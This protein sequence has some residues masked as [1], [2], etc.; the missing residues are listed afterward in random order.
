M[1]SGA[2]GPG[3][4]RGARLSPQTILD[5]AP[6]LLYSLGL[7]VPEDLEGRVMVDLF[8]PEALAGEP[9]RVEGRTAGAEEARE[10]TAGGAMAPEE[11]AQVLERLKALGYL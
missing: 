7:P 1:R 10:T 8:A 11:E 5:V 3:I 6:T 4:R 9:V 2:A